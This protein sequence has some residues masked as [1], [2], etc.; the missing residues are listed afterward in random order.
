[1]NTIQEAID[2]E[3]V[4]FSGMQIMAEWI[5]DRLG[6]EG[7]PLDKETC[8]GDI[9]AIGFRSFSCVAA[10]ADWGERQGKAAEALRKGMREDG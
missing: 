4:L 7:C 2:K 10:V 3:M 5:V 1:M 9:D 8:G 6:C